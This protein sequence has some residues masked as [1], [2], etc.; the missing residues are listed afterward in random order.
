[1]MT[2]SQP[3]AVAA[4]VLRR[5]YPVPR[6]RVFAAWT[7]PAMIAHFF[8]VDE[9]KA[10]ANSMDVKTGGAFRISLLQ[11]DGETFVARGIYTEVTPPERLVMTWT[12]EEDDPSEEHE[13][14]LSLAFNDLGGKTE[15]VLTHEKLASVESRARHE[16]GWSAMI[17][18]LTEVLAER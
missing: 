11:P 15:L 14:L 17:D 7:D 4:L 1:M 9:M 3:A 10:T 6:E 5:T 2:N 8:S 16:G 12:W 18:Q 13:T